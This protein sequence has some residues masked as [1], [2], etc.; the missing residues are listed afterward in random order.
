M[1]AIQAGKAA[2]FVLSGLAVAVIAAGGCGAGRSPE[3]TPGMRTLTPPAATA[4]ID[5]I[6]VTVSADRSEAT[7]AIATETPVS[8]MPAALDP[9]GPWLLGIGGDDRLVAL[10][11]D[12]SGLTPLAHEPLWDSYPEVR[13]GVELSGTGWI[14][15][16]T[17]ASRWPIPPTDISLDLFQLP[18]I[19]PVRR[20]PLFS[21]ELVA[22]MG[23]IG[24][25]RLPYEAEP[26]EGPNWQYEMVYLV[27]LP[28]RNPPRW[29]PDGRYLAF[30]G[31]MDGPSSDLY[32]YD[33]QT[34]LVRRLTDGPNQAAIMGWSPD[35]RWI[36]HVEA[37]TYMIAD[38]G[39]IGGFPGDAVWAAAVDGS[40][41]KRLYEPARVEWIH[42]WVSDT[43][44]LVEGWSGYIFL[45]D[46]RAVDVGTGAE[47]MHYPGKYYNSALAP[48]PAV[49]VVDAVSDCCFDAESPPP[50]EDEYFPG[51][52]HL[53]P[54]DG[55]VPKQLRPGVEEFNARW[56]EWFP[57]LDRF[58]AG[59]FGPP[60]LFTSSGEITHTFQDE[61]GRPAVS[62]DGSWLVF[63]EERERPGLRLYRVG[64]EL[65]REISEESAFNFVWEPDSSGL[66][67]LTR[68]GQTNNL[69]VVAIPEG[70]P[71]L[72]HPSLGI[73]QFTLVQGTEGSR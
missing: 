2:W 13:E 8:T 23:Q 62:P 50:S 12:G 27:V 63:D 41:L 44:F 34:D 73:Y 7:I 19:Q 11:P 30:A 71:V 47:K 55:G 22:R 51:G 24:E 49:A 40:E 66:Y 42:G 16:R 17:S 38:G 4:T 59:G 37:S 61:R 29:S 45:H 6:S 35:S 3:G 18:D 14:A 67:Y 15:V 58:F 10:N 68:V 72:V 21:Q 65:V 70:E 28:E 64:G 57:Q 39:E 26:V 69:M 31:A 52:L 32:V 33:T 60:Y 53:V 20:F 56:L 46:L 36:I 9:E 48:G 1:S 25:H 5:P 43:V 54:L